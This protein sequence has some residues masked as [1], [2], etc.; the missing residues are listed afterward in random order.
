M[1]TDDTQVS[2]EHA[3]PRGVSCSICSCAR[4]LGT[5]IGAA[6]SST[7]GA[8]NS[9]DVDT[10]IFQNGFIQ[11]YS[12]C[13]RPEAGRQIQAGRDVFVQYQCQ[14]QIPCNKESQLISVKIPYTLTPNSDVVL[15]GP[16]LIMTSLDQQSMICDPAIKFH[17]LLV[18][19][20]ILV[21]YTDSCVLYLCICTHYIMHVCGTTPSVSVPPNKAL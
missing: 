1:A 2:M 13:C 20:R 4:T 21:K 16:S 5:Y 18:T 3:I 15:H 17:Y 7:Q 11:N 14:K 12:V 9:I 6:I 19:C 8:N 10:P